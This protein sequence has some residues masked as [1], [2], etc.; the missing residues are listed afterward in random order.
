MEEPTP[1]VK[2]NVFPIITELAGDYKQYFGRF[3]GRSLL[4]KGD[5][6]SREDVVYCTVSPYGIVE[7]RPF[8][9]CE[10]RRDTNTFLNEAMIHP[11]VHSFFSCGGALC[12]KKRRCGG[13]NSGLTGLDENAI[14][15]KIKDGL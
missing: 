15:K 1:R 14:L 10:G 4:Q 3:L 9:P 8:R 11:R 13:G 2:I 12:G 7:R 5:C 6:F